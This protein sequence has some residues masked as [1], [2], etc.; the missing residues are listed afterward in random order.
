MALFR[1]EGWCQPTHQN[2]SSRFINFLGLVTKYNSHFI[3]MWLQCY[4]KENRF[5]LTSSNS[6]RM[7]HIINPFN[8]NSKKI[9]T[10]PMSNFPW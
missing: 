8:K 9:T 2:P 4:T 7:L 1:M 5:L 3:P 6:Y 10:G